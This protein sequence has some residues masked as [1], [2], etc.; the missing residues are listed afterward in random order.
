MTAQG[1]EEQVTKAHKIIRN[2]SIGI[3]IVLSSYLISAY[4]ADVFLA[5][6]QGEV[7]K[8]EEFVIREEL[9]KLRRALEELKPAPEKTEEVEER[10]EFV[11]RHEFEEFKDSIVQLQKTFIDFFV[12]YGLELGGRPSSEEQQHFKEQVKRLLELE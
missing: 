1:N 8:R 6:T 11:T 9:E 5:T 7:E 10:E 4:V 12:T 2:G 3:L